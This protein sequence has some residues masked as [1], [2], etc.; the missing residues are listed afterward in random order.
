MLTPKQIKFI[1]EELSTAK[2]PLFFF[3]DDPDGICSFLLLYRLHK[4]G[5]GV[6]LKTTPVLDNK[7]INKV[8][9]YR[10]DKIF[11]LDI[12]IVQ[13]EFIDSAKRPFFWLDHH[14]PLER[15]HVH[16]FNPRIKKSDIYLPTSY[17]GYQLNK[18]DLWLAMVGCIA[19]WHLPDFAEKFSKEY[20]DLLPKVTTIDEAY[21][22]QPIS[23]LVKMFS[24]LLK[25][26][27]SEVLKR[28]RILSRIKSPYELTKQTTSQGNYLYNA[29]ERINKYYEPLIKTALE[30]KS[31]GKVHLFTYIESQWSF[32]P[33]LAAEL[34]HNNP[35]KVVIIARHKSGEMKCS[36]RSRII[37]IAPALERA[38]EGIEGYGGG[39]EYACGAVIKEQ[40]WDKFLKQ[41][42]K[43]LPK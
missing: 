18:K 13:Q 24:F 29:F 23:Q 20:P 15:E 5:H 42:K 31:K 19:D 40:D 16:Y 10:P 38:L 41:F 39:H 37:P 32:T 2:N 27:T 25:G 9:E 6:I 35:K 14:T 36:L 26:K 28:I 11:A 7:F 3:D 12:P 30:K 17:F 33:D 43:E 34:L 22:D 8:K 21:F 4:K 1:K